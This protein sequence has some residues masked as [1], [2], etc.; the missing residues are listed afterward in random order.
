MLTSELL[1]E[2]YVHKLNLPWKYHE[3]LIKNVPTIIDEYIES[4]NLCVRI[5]GI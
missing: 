2:P 3:N 5:I 4:R 1:L